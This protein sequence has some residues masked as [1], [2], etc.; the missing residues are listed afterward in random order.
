MTARSNQLHAQWWKEERD[1]TRARLE[2]LKAAY[3]DKKKEV[4]RLSNE[5]YRL[6][7]RI[8]E[9]QTIQDFADFEG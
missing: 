1:S 7:Q 4:Q 6:K 5:N 8:A 2:K 3:L 9:L